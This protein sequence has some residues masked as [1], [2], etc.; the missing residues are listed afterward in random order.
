MKKFTSYKM[1]AMCFS[2]KV[3]SKRERHF[4]LTFLLK[5]TIT[6]KQT[7]N[8]KKKH[9]HQNTSQSQSLIVLSPFIVCLSVISLFLF[10]QRKIYVH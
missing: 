8:N 5:H 3:C 9:Q 1:F 10:S 6:D 4:L 2:V 7:N